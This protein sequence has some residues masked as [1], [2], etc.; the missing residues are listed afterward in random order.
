MSGKSNKLG[1]SRAVNGIQK[2]RSRSAKIPA[3]PLGVLSIT[4]D[5]NVPLTEVGV[6]QL[7]F[8]MFKDECSKI[9]PG[10][11][12][13]AESV[14]RDKE[15]LQSNKITHIINCAGH[16]FQNTFPED[17]TYLTLYL[18]D[19]LVEDIRC[20]LYTCFDFIE[21]A[22]QSNGCVLVHCMQGVSRST[23]VVIG[24]LMWKMN[25]RYDVVFN[26]VKSIRGIANP[27]LGFATQLIQIHKQQ[28][29]DVK[30]DS[31]QAYRMSPHCQADALRIVPKLIRRAVELEALDSRIA[32]VFRCYDRTFIWQGSD[33]TED[34]VS[35]AKV[36]VDQLIK[37]E[38][39]PENPIRIFQGGEPDQLLLALENKRTELATK[40]NAAEN[41][42]TNEVE[43]QW[44]S[45]AKVKQLQ[46]SSRKEERA[47]DSARSYKLRKGESLIG[48][49]TCAGESSLLSPRQ[50]R[51]KSFRSQDTQ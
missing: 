15:Q 5:G 47:I 7:K 41:E 14:A 29:Q 20:V 38:Q 39:A 1:L 11:F 17:F 33:A 6:R 3:L 8:A 25:R 36:F 9:A 18:L 51:R 12:V 42:D 32:Y 45:Q 19:S 34:F 44:Y 50:V 30:D 28:T 16:A 26:E 2:Q 37:Y 48:T 43:F 31:C 24:Y 22:L 40:D 21:E 13:S 49:P 10:L 35:A 27:N 4:P 46:S 23:A